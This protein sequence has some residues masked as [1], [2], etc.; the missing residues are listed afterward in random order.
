MN[1]QASYGVWPS[2]NM[3]VVFVACKGNKTKFRDIIKNKILL[4]LQMVFERY[5]KIVM[6][7]LHK[8]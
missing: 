8:P 1:D 3:A 7:M 5:S 6:G 2:A 4:C